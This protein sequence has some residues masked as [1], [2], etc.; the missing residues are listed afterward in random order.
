[1]G[2]GW[3]PGSGSQGQVLNYQFDCGNLPDHDEA[4]AT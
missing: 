3:K 1:M 2:A 4:A